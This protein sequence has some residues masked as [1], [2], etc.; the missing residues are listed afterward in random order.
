MR[1]HAQARP[2]AIAFRFLNDLASAPQEL[3]YHQ[4]WQEAGVVANFLGT[5]AS[6]GSR[7][8]LFYPPG[9]EYIKAFYG[10]MLAG[11]V[12]VPLYP[13]RRNSKSDRLTKVAR[14]C[15][16]VLA[17]T[18]ESELAAVQAAWN[19]QAEPGMALAFHVTDTLDVTDA[20]PFVPPAIDPAVPAFLQY[21][22]G[23]TGAPKGVII[24]HANIMANMRHLSLMSGGHAGDVFVN[25]LP[26]FHDLGLV[27]AVLWPVSLGASSTLMAPATFVR[28]PLLWLQA[29]TRYRGSMCGAPNFA[30]ALCVDKIADASLTKLDLSSWRVAYNA[31]EPVRAATLDAF[32]TRFGACGFRPQTFYPSYG[33]AEA[34]VFI[35]G[36]NAS[37]APISLVVDRQELAARRVTP[38]DVGDALATRIVACGAASAP[39]DLRVVDPESRRELA[40]GQVGEI[41]FAGPSVSPGYWG[42]GAQTAEAFGQS[43][44][45]S[46]LPAAYLRTGDLGVMVDGELYVTGRIK[47][48]VILNG[49]NYYP[50]DIELSA[51]A[52]HRAI[53]PGHV[54]AF[55]VEEDLVERLVVVA[56]VEREHFRSLDVD[57]VVAAVRQQVLR[58]HEINA[59]RIVLVKPYKVP[60]T[61]SGK[62]QRRQARAMLLDGTLEV[63]ASSATAAPHCAAPAT[64]T[65]H[66][67]APIW[68]RVLGRA[69]IGTDENF[70]DLGGDSLAAAEIAAAL[71]RHRSTE[72]DIG[73]FFDTPTITGLAGWLDLVDAHS[74]RKSQLMAVPAAAVVRV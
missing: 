21:T 30:Y 57:H 63:L 3:N 8:M 10:C 2:D 39:H 54:A 14:S 67:L 20:R 44:C 50:Q 25:W 4:L 46:D 73:Q 68:C 53:R 37:A 40:D 19:E 18:T 74:T 60:V 64:A 35:S 66:M 58:D 65:E 47:D 28:D 34:T 55:A 9:L 56:E 42:L 61:S 12:A 15:Q 48:L 69:Q 16:S 51:T 71:G 7:I 52:A 41:W 49:R 29:I 17:L 11:M 24:T 45:N 13:P 22:S 43:I 38:V 5:V 70:F 23:S 62:I 32:G 1:E 31:A 33:M 72:L 6:P 59:D 26:L 27:T 36:G